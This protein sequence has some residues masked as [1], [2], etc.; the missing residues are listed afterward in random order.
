[1]SWSRKRSNFCDELLTDDNTF[2]IINSLM[3]RQ[4][5]TDN[6]PFFRGTFSLRMIDDDCSKSKIESFSIEDI[7]EVKFSLLLV[8]R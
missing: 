6:I 4:E 7:L 5:M 3:S 8:I 2:E 1:M